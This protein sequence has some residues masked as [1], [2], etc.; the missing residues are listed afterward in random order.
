MPTKFIFLVL[1]FVLSISNTALAQTVILQGNPIILIIDG[2][3]KISDVKSASFNNKTVPVFLY[4][5]KPTVLFGIDLNQK[6]GSYGFAYELTNGDLYGRLI[7]VE[8]REKPREELGIPEKLGGNTPQAQTAL[9][10]NLSAENSVLADLYTGLRNFWST[11]FQYPVPNPVITDSYGYIRETGN[12]LISHKGVDFRAQEGTAVKTMNRGVVRLVK[13]FT[14][15]G[16]TIVV[17][18]GLGVL[19]MYMHLSESKVNAG[20]LVLPGQVIGLSGKTG[21][22]ENPH[23]HIT[24]RINGISIDPIQFLSLFAEKKT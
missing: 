2:A 10:N 17:D 8:V 24:V 16:K 23:L 9:V 6:S 3:S 5:N 12:Y 1:F 19:T 20:E 15:Y 7:R 18:H 21:Y 11:P 22:A 13:N 4:D 14:I